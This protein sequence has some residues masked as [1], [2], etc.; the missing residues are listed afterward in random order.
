MTETQLGV[1][2]ARQP[3]GRCCELLARAGVEAQWWNSFA[4]NMEAPQIGMFGFFV[5]AGIRH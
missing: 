3:T 2:W 1:E 5:T 4:S